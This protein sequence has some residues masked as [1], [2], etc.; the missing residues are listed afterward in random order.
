[1][2]SVLRAKG[3]IR[4]LNQFVVIYDQIKAWDPTRLV[5][6]H[7]GWR[8]VRTDIADSH[9]YTGDVTEWRGVMTLLETQPMMLE[10][11]GY[12]Y[13]GQPLMMSEYGVGWGDDRSWGFKWQTSEIRR[14]AGVVGYT[15]TE[16]LVC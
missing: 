3:T 14:R 11:L 15:Y 9:K 6:D 1:V 16:L 5:I 2:I 12:S 10:V 4:S 7:S 13:A 8:Y